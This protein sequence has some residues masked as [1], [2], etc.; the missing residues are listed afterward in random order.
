MDGERGVCVCVRERE[1]ERE[2]EIVTDKVLNTH[3]LLQKIA[4]I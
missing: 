2:K 4:D 3:Q 1:R